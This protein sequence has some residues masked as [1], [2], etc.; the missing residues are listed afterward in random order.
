M[1]LI[2]KQKTLISLHGPN[3]EEEQRC[4]FDPSKA[5]LSQFGR[6]HTG[7]TEWFPENLYK[8]T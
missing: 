1:K 6:S 5:L 8:L 4:L 7:L 3:D 2:L